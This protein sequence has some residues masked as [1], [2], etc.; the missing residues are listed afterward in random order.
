M[1]NH[2]IGTREEWLAARME[3]LKA[4]KELTRRN[5]ELA[6]QRQALP[7]VKVER[8][9]QFDSE[10]GKVNLKDL[11]KGNSQLIIYH[12]MYGPDFAAGCPSCSSVADGFNGIFVH[13]ENHDVA[14]TA[15]SRAP[16]QTLQAYK[17]RMGWSFPWASSEGSDFNSDFSV[18]FTEEQQ[19]QGGITYNFS[20]EPSFVWRPGK[21]G[22]G[23]VAE[24]EFAKMCGIDTPTFHRDRPGMSA[25]ALQ[26]GV[27]YHTY[28]AYARGLDGLWN[29]YQWLDRAPLGR[30]EAGGLWFRRHDEYATANKGSCCHSS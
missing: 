13:L 2:K 6:Q 1:N 18:S 9:Y 26:D 23:E 27:V 17:K 14:F 28:S 12:F 11:F 16:L 5:D 21:E 15:I 8:E 3:L 22:G 29:M 24:S 30:N 19:S 7:W 25:F 10:A 4:E 20:E